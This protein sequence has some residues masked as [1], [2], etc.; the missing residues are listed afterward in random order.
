MAKRIRV[1]DL[2]RE[3]DADLDEV[4]VALWDVGLDVESP[5]DAIASET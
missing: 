4:I 1:A 3:A 2:A 5:E